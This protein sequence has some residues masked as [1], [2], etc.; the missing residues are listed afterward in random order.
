MAG[1]ED[2]FSSPLFVPQD[3]P[4]LGACG[5]NNGHPGTPFEE[6]DL[7]MSLEAPDVD[8]DHVDDLEDFG[9]PE[10]EP[11]KAVRSIFRLPEAGHTFLVGTQ[12]SAPQASV[13]TEQSEDVEMGAGPI[14]GR[15]NVPFTSLPT[16]SPLAAF[17]FD[18]ETDAGVFSFGESHFN[19]EVELPGQDLPV[20]Q[21]GEDLS[22]AQPHV[23]REEES[24][25]FPSFATDV[26]QL[27]FTFN[28]PDPHFGFATEANQRQFIIG[29]HDRDAG[30]E[31]R[32][33][34]PFNARYPFGSP[35]PSL[36]PM[37]EDQAAPAS[38]VDREQANSALLSLSSQDPF[39]LPRNVP[40]LK[41]ESE[42][43]DIPA[44]AS[45]IEREPARST[46]SPPS[47]QNPVD[48]PSVKPELEEK[49]A[50]TP[51]IKREPPSSTISPFTSRAERARRAQQNAI[52]SETEM[53][54]QE[55]TKVGSMASPQVASART[56]SGA[57]KE[58]IK[59]KE[60]T[61]PSAATFTH[62]ARTRERS[63]TPFG[64][65]SKD[66]SAT[67]NSSTSAE[68]ET[69]IDNAFKK[70]VSPGRLRV[71][72]VDDLTHEDMRNIERAQER[73]ANSIR[74]PGPH[75]LTNEDIH[76]N[77]RVRKLADKTIRVPGLQPLTYEDMLHN[78]RVRKQRL[79]DN[80][81]RV[82]GPHPLTF[83]DH[84]H[85]ERVLERAANR[86]NENNSGNNKENN[87]NIPSMFISQP[88]TKPIVNFS[89][90]TSPKPKIPATPE[91]LMAAARQQLN[92]QAKKYR[93]LENDACDREEEL[94]DHWAIAR[95]LRVR[96]IEERRN[97]LVVIRHRRRQMAALQG[98][99][100]KEIF[101]RG[102]MALLLPLHVEKEPRAGTEEFERMV[103]EGEEAGV[104]DDGYDT[105]P[106]GGSG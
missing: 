60:A 51:T 4:E 8:M 44:P 86:S 104:E 72:D 53:F 3:S 52:K 31:V 98:M 9:N 1:N 54:D 27:D 45:I 21:P 101:E 13:A 11:A 47:S 14:V 76:H 65:K 63:G 25:V 32:Q 74:V 61:L 23:I 82:P 35:L 38:A 83:E 43:E 22:I 26:G 102:L 79:A 71:P 80:T 55:P 78:E 19:T 28:Q 50:T 49:P 73:A 18:F 67:I 24:E 59:T 10:P 37:S 64:I 105:P 92:D 7:G 90:P 2:S 85:N 96:A 87:P 93:E 89:N 97:A 42:G 62:V 95:H 17:D 94:A 103:I 57:T 84:L 29:Q 20:A 15:D 39:D 106:F 66:N 88:T 33:E 91:N 75:P 81:I 40:S 34:S 100:A 46:L 70:L 58:K 99:S 30:R 69:A 68:A 12:Q 41:S 16:L 5:T 56:R 6:L 48:F 36:Q 77:E